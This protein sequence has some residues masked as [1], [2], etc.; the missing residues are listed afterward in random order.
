M[1]KAKSKL[2]AGGFKNAK[3][4]SLVSRLPPLCRVLVCVF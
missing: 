4:K 1:V 2:V 3:E